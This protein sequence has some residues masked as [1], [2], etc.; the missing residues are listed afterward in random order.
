MIMIFKV[1]FLFNVL[2]ISFVWKKEIWEDVSSFGAS[3]CDRLAV[4]P[5]VIAPSGQCQVRIA[6]GSCACA[7]QK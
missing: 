1:F 7:L 2:K 4:M 6:L 5:A 3:W